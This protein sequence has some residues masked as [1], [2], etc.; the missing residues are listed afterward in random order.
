MKTF[1]AIVIG[2][3]HSGLVAATLLAKAGRSTLLLERSER[4][5]GCAMTT[6]IARGY[7]VPTLAH[8][9]AID[10][11][12]MRELQLE[13]HGLKPIRSSAQ[14]CAPT[15]DGRAVTLWTETGRTAREL[16]AWSSADSARVVP[17]IDSLRAVTSVLASVLATPPP[18]IDRPAPGDLLDLLKAARRFRALGKADAYRLLRW[19]PMPAAD[20]VSEWFESEPLRAAIAAGGILGSP[21]G[22][23]EA[24]SAAIL[25]LLA[26]RSDSLLGGGWTARGG[27]G[28]LADALASAATAAA[29]SVRTNAAVRE[30]TVKDGTATGV[31]LASGEELYAQTMV[32]ALDPRRTLLDLVDPVHLGPG[33]LEE[34]RHIR[35]R[36]VLAKVNYAVSGLPRFGSSA[37]AGLSSPDGPLAGVIRLA[38][39]LDSI[40]RAYDASKYGAIPQEPW[41][42]LTIPSLADPDLAPAGHHVVSAYAQYAPFALRGSTWDAERDRFGDIVTRTIGAFAPGFESTVLARQVITPADLE[43]IYGLTG[44]HIF[45]GELA[46]DQLLLARPLLGHARYTTP[47]RGL[48]LCSAGTH[49]GLGLDGRSAALAVKQILKK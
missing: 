43:S 4:V 11:G 31:V 30:I 37:G 25:L 6:E 24:G 3:G 15:V 21:L 40:E 16:A 22:P 34:V 20:F 8:R 17:F 35:M 19:L 23:R 49:P 27:P 1:D 29:V 39:N 36:G 12:L 28:A 41:I 5:G 44:G 9:M 46:L 18:P 32:S 47:I 2:G 7:R 48:H 45:H 26:S 42:E 13:L 10:A 33:F 38:R 14:V